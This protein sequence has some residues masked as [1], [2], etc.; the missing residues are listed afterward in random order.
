[1]AARAHIDLALPGGLVRRYSLCGDPA[2]RQV[3]QVAV[4]REP[5]GRGGSLYVHEDLVEGASVGVAGPRNHFVFEPARRYLLIAGGIGITPLVPMVAAA[6]A[7]GA[8][9]SPA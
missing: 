7:S 6:A 2:D 8:D 5:D 1:V 9:W 4:L 3:W